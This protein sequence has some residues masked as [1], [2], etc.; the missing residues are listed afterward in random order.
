MSPTPGDSRALRPVAAAGESAARSVLERRV[1]ELEEINAQLEEASRLKSEFLASTSHELRTPLNG[2]LG[3]LQLVLDGYCTSA[4]EQREFLRQTLECSRQLLALINDVLDI[5]RIEA[6]RMTL[7]LESL[8][9]ARVFDDV[10]IVTHVQASQKGVALRF[11]TPEDPLRVRADSAK[12]RQVLINLVANSLKFTPRGT[13]EVRARLHADSGYAWIEV[14]DTGIG[15]AHDRLEAIFDPYVQAAPGTQRTYGGTGLGLAICRCLVELQG[16]VI[17]ASSDGNDKG[18]RFG[19]AL[20]VWRDDVAELPGVE[21]DE[22]RGPADGPIVLVVE[23]DARVREGLVATLNE[24]G[25]RTLAAAGAD[26]GWTL[27]TTHTLAAVVCDYAL[28]AGDAPSLRSGWDLAVRLTQ[29]PALRSIPF[30]FVT[31]FESELRAR[32]SACAAS[33]VAAAQA[34]SR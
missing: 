4:G 14:R 27:A 30:V 20:P 11:V 6:G 31:P 9:I 26:R 2:I 34:E 33:R 22:L 1:R 17:G 32:L 8:E 23:D 12:L 3:F 15:I 25:Y 29:E 7:E 5:A 10:Q 24:H 13:I 16:G 18:S 21:P 28:H 19:F